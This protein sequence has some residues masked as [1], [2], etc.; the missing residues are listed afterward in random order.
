M[1]EETKIT[2]R[3]PAALHQWLAA[4]AKSSRRSLNSEIVYRLESERA[5]IET[6]IETP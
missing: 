1:N 6:D 3:L 4:Q 2:L 5:A